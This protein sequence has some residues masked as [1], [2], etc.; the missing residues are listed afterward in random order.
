M[1]N[2]ISDQPTIDEAAPRSFDS[3]G[4][5]RLAAAVQNE[6]DSG[7][8]PGATILLARGGTIGYQQAFG[9][10]GPDSSTPMSMDAIFRIYS[11]TKPVVSV[12]IMMLV[13]KGR[14]SL[15]DPVEKWLPEFADLQVGRDLIGDDGVRSMTLQACQRPMTIQDLLRHTAGLTYGIF[16]APTL[17]KA[18]YRAAG[19]ERRNVT[20]SALITGL[21]QLPLAFQ[22]GSV[23]EYS[24]A[25]DVLG[26]LLERMSGQTLDV[27][28]HQHIFAPL[29]M[30]DTGFIV[31]T[32]QQHR[33]AEPFDI[34]PL[35]GR[36]VSLLDVC[37]KPDFLSGGGGLVSTTADYLRFAHML[38]QQGE[39]DGVRLLSRK[40]VQFMTSDHLV[41]MP[42]ATEGPDY[43]PG[44][45]YG[46][47]LGFAIRTA[48]GAATT[49]GSIGE[50][51]WSGLAGT[52]FWIDPV[53]DLIA[54]WMVQAPE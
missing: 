27:Y 32:A 6:V 52:F 45:G 36:A 19:I 4:L 29:G 28:L 39:I 26:A 34:D 30:I 48:V 10:L 9:R 53:E 15:A 49:P 13:E 50:F 20:N 1:H 54:I 42:H 47:G 16:G 3:R 21:S 35:T 41:G 12:A 8:I 33:I 7:Q 2:I 24:R 31:P 44:P 51:H 25:T 40:T 23:W 5:K 11:M 22:P 17:V 43:L 18:A 46:F 37:S 14:L 38:R